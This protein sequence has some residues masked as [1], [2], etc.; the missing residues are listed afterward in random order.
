MKRLAFILFATLLMAGN[1]IAQNKPTKGSW[2]TEVQINP[3]DQD[4]ET[5]SLDGL[6][7]RYF[8]SDKNA[9]RL[10]IGFSSTSSK[11]TDGDTEEKTEY[12]HSYDYQYKYKMGNLNIDLGYERHFDLGKRFDAYL[13]GSVGFGKNFASTKVENYSKYIYN[14]GQNIYETTTTGELKNSAIT[15]DD[16]ISDINKAPKA[17]WNINAALF[18]GLDFYVYKGLYIGTE[19]GIKCQSQKTL[20]VEYDGTT[21][22]KTTSNGHTEVNEET[23]N[24]ENTNN[25]RITNFKTYIEPRLRIGITF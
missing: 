15:D 25:Y 3:F 20:K 8:L 6:K 12:T 7:V 5:F 2:S 10:K 9:I 13:G 16:D 1:A 23:V 4:G 11:Y 17:T 19:L 21:I 14:D 22:S 24:E 18:A